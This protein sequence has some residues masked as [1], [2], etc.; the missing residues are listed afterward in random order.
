MVAYA[1]AVF[2]MA[3]A[4]R[5]KI[6]P[7]HACGV[8]LTP[9]A[10]LVPYVVFVIP[11]PW[12]LALIVQSESMFWTSTV[13]SIMLMFPSILVG[14]VASSWILLLDT[15]AR[16]G[17]KMW[18]ALLSF[19]IPSAI[20]IYLVISAVLNVSPLMPDGYSAIF[21]LLALLFSLGGLMHLHR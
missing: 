20:S 10:R 8:F 16:Y 11:I 13:L 15:M 2:L 1:L 12:L 21:S 4:V 14:L 7:E 5:E 19:S 3:L 9:M 17:K 6:D 18:P